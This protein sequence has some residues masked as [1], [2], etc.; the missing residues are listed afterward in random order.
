MARTARENLYFIKMDSE[1]GSASGIYRGRLAPTPSGRLHMGHARTFWFAH[2]RCRAAGGVMVYRNDDLDRERSRDEF[3]EAA[4]VD[5]KWLGFDWEEGPFAQSGR[6][7]L[8]RAAFERLR[9]KGRVYPCTCTRRDLARMALAPHAGEEGGVYPGTCRRRTG[10]EGLTEGTF[11]WRFR[12][13]DGTAVEFLDEARG[14]CRFVAGEDF[15]DFVVLGRNGM[16]S[17]Q[18]ATVVDDAEMGITEVVRGEDLLIST[19]RQILLFEA[20]GL[21][22]PKFFHTRLLTD[23]KGER[24]AKRSDS[25]SLEVLREQGAKPEAWFREW[26]KADF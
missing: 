20:L 18:L 12:V 6:L 11:A 24:L 14:V 21:R 8:Y 15:G 19:A 1:S 7:A 22:C 2:Q 23:E 4:R 26:E 16:P 17:Y 9:M 25:L 5:L 10:T 13:E 3:A